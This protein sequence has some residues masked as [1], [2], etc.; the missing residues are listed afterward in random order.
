MFLIYFFVKEKRA[1]NVATLVLMFHDIS[2]ECDPSKT[3]LT[4]DI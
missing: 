1:M 4:E 3:I 2:D